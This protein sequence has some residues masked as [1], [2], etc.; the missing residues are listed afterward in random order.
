MIRGA[1][2]LPNIITA[3]WASILMSADVEHYCR[4][5]M[6]QI[7]T[8][9]KNVISS[10]QSLLG[11]SPANRLLR[12]DRCWGLHRPSGDSLIPMSNDERYQVLHRRRPKR[13]RLVF[14]NYLHQYSYPRGVSTCA[15]RNLAFSRKISVVIDL[16]EG[17]RW[18]SQR[19]ESPL[20][21][22]VGIPNTNK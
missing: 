1:K 11:E 21:L 14:L 3:D 8:F 2:T 10:L 22:S 16:H 9:V 13:R 5:A 19:K 12:R 15:V 18:G 20:N 6:I 17:S 7:G 4:S